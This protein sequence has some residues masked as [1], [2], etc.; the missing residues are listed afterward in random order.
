[1]GACPRSSV[2]RHADLIGLLGLSGLAVGLGFV[3]GRL[4]FGLTG[5]ATAIAGQLAI[6][7]PAAVATVL[8]GAVN[9]AAGAVVVRLVR[10]TPFASL[11]EL[12]L[13]GF[14]GAVLL[15]VALV[16]M[17]ANAPALFARPVLVAIHA[18]LMVIGWRV[19]RPLAAP[20]RAIVGRPSLLWVL[21]GVAWSGPLLLQAASPVV[22]FFDVLPNHVAPV[23]HLATFGRFD[24]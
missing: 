1:M 7:L 9:I 21:V 10:R 18:L 3:P 5:A 2:P 12:V 4:S 13:A 24:P 15:D 22:P 14:L 6:T 23:A 11:T 20:W 8:A 17:L 16:C 19:A